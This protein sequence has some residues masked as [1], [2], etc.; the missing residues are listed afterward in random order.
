MIFY[1]RTWLPFSIGATLTPQGVQRRRYGGYGTVQCILGTRDL[2]K[3]R[4]G[5]RKNAKYLDGTRDL[6]APREAALAKIWPRDAGFFRLS[7]GNS[8]NRHDSNKR[9]RGQSKSARVTLSGVFF[10]TIECAWLIVV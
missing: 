7:V 10:Q 4:F 2:T 3:I 9:C 5:N 8:G 1:V 6:T